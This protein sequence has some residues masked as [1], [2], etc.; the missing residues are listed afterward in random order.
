MIN[1]TAGTVAVTLGDPLRIPVLLVIPAIAALLAGCTVSANLTVSA[2]SVAEQ[3]AA[4]LQEQ[5]GS[6]EPP[7]LDCGNGSVDLK[8][9][10]VVDCVLTEPTD[11]TEYATAVTLSDIDGTKY[12]IDVQVAST[13]VAGAETPETTES[14][15][16]SALTVPASELAA[17]AQQALAPQLDYDPVVYCTE[18][19]VPVETGQEV[20]CMISGGAASTSVLIT[21]TEADGADYKISAVIQ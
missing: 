2:D 5:V 20:R 4:A 3:A 8:E 7:A 12:H 1:C 15:S 19:D 21:V 10:E 16:Q 17:L 14:E 11:G 6:A 18:A 9:G 13:P